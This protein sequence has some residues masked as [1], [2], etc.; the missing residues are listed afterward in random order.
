MIRAI[1]FDL[2]NT[3]YNED[4][5][6]LKVFE[7]FSD[8]HGLDIER[9]KQKF[10]AEF[11]LES[12]DIFGDILKKI[13]FYTIENQNELFDL[14]ASI[15]CELR[16]YDDAYNVLEYAKKHNLKVVVITNG[17][18]KVQ[19]NKVKVL[20]ISKKVSNII[21]ARE[22]G[23]EHEKPSPYA[24]NKALDILGVGISEVLYVGD[25]PQTDIKGAINVGI[26]AIRFMSGYASSIK[27][28]HPDNIKN[29]SEI[30]KYVEGEV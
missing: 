20:N 25:H 7:E 29:L 26:R 23:V 6:F 5:Y 21:Y 18:I 19:K 17:I 12:K 24:F 10:S 3:L 16:L 8:R 14:Y 9:I 28:D 11:R 15:D 13:G 2:D 30:K 27:Y 1:I 4:L 22:L